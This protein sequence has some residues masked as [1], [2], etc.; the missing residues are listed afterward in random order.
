MIYF[1]IF[2]SINHVLIEEFT[3]FNMELSKSSQFTIYLSFSWI[4]IFSNCCNVPSTESYYH[5]TSNKK[6]N[7]LVEEEKIVIQENDK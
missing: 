6:N 5:M 1:L 7:D 3:R 4:T 2:D